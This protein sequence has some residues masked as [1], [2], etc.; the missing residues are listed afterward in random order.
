MDTAMTNLQ[1]AQ[2]DKI[3]LTALDYLGFFLH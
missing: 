2:T 1:P 3:C